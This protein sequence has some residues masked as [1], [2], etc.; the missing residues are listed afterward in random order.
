MGLRDRLHH[1]QA[2]AEP[3]GLPAAARVDAG[4]PAEDPPD[5]GRRDAGSGVGD[6]QDDVVAVTAG[7]QLDPPGRVRVVDRVLDECVQGEGQ[8]VLVGRDAGFRQ[9]AERPAPPGLDR[10]SVV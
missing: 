8:A 4:E 5:L 7:A 1:R 10:K 2:E 6:G 9:R 3:A